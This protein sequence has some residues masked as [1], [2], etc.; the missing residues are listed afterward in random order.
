V[1][2]ER[3]TGESE[4]PPEEREPDSRLSDM[5]IPNCAICGRPMFFD[6]REQRWSCFADNVNLTY[7]EAAGKF[8]RKP[9]RNWRRILAA[10]LLCAIPFTN[11]YF[12]MSAYDRRRLRKLNCPNCR[13]SATEVANRTLRLKNKHFE[14]ILECRC[15]SCGAVWKRSEA[16]VP[17]LSM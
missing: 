8:S 15:R 11:P 1:P 3:H 7:D 17:S 2:P 5:R 4:E 6:E 13:S 14:T 12:F 10:A 9:K 16:G